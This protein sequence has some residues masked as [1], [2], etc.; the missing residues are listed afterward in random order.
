MSLVLRADKMKIWGYL[1]RIPGRVHSTLVKGKPT[2]HQLLCWKV[3]LHHR[4]EAINGSFHTGTAYLFTSICQSPVAIWKLFFQSPHTWNS[5]GG[6][7]GVVSGRNQICPS[8]D[9]RS[10]KWSVSATIQIHSKS[11]HSSFVQ[12]RI[13]KFGNITQKTLKN[14]TT[15]EFKRIVFFPSENSICFSQVPRI[16]SFT[17]F[18]LLTNQKSNG[19]SQTQNHFLKNDCD[20]FIF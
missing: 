9:F 10:N 5:L 3:P 2:S 1:P 6:L 17:L 14:L 13:Y 12:I 15:P 8:S 7:S 16:N 20:S 4:N 19:E 18:T 11:L